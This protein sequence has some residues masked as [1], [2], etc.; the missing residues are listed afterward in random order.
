MPSV[1]S[2]GDRRHMKEVA[3]T[4]IMRCPSSV[5]ECIGASTQL[6]GGTMMDRTRLILSLAGLVLAA[7]AVNAE[8]PAPTSVTLF[9]QKYNI[10]KHSLQGSYKNGVKITQVTDWADHSESRKTKVD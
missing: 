8:Q 10:I 5:H 2:E 7:G 1:V 9:G 6:N 4:S 3:A